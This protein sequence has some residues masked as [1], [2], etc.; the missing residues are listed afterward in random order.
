V[1]KELTKR[2]N[3]DYKV[4]KKESKT[5]KKEKTE[6]MKTKIVVLDDNEPLVPG[7]SEDEDL[8]SDEPPK[9]EGKQ[10]ST[11]EQKEIEE[12]KRKLVQEIKQKAIFQAQCDEMKQMERSSKANGRNKFD[13][14]ESDS[15]EHR[16]RKE[17]KLKKIKK[18]QKEKPER[19]RKR[20]QSSSSDSDSDSSSSSSQSRKVT[21]NHYNYYGSMPKKA[22]KG[23]RDKKKKR[24]D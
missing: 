13:N 6:T 4:D 10:G 22:H 11:P 20:S 14:S 8:G 1:E 3:T 18:Q 7:G 2:P 9:L 24:K 23:G 21:V 16:K 12:L 17:K 19:K 5:E 15:D